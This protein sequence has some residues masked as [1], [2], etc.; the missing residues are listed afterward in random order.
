MELNASYICQTKLN[1]L[2]QLTFLFLCNEISWLQPQFAMQVLE[3]G[4][5]PKQ[6]GHLFSHEVWNINR[7]KL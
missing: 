2:K 6:L 3:W 4:T 1:K 7:K 5:K